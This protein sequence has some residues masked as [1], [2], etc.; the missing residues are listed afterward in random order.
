LYELYD[1]KNNVL[2]KTFILTKI[3]VLSYVPPLIFYNH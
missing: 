1:I 2:I 3:L